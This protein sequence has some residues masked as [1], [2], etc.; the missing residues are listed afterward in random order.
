VCDEHDRAV[1]CVEGALQLVDRRKVEM[2]RRL[3]EDQAVDAASGEERDERAR[4]L[5]R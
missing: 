4:A 2:V 5:A 3:V 1:E